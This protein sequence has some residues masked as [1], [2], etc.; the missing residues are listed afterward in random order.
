MIKL[1]GSREA[2][3]A[4]KPYRL[5]NPYDVTSLLQHIDGKIPRD[6]RVRRGTIEY[7]GDDDLEWDL[8][9][10]EDY[11]DQPLC[12]MA[13]KAGY[14]IVILENMVGSFQVVTEVLDVR[15]RKDSFL[16]LIYTY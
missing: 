6:L 5:M 1:L 12:S 14:D 16:S 9:A 3:R 10:A 13:A 4:S 2:F 7:Y 11:L 15:S 8:Y